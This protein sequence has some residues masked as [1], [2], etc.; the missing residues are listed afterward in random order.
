MLLVILWA[1]LYQD[2]YVNTDER[3]LFI[4]M[5]FKNRLTKYLLHVDLKQNVKN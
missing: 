5:F 4:N 1:C 2:N 3:D